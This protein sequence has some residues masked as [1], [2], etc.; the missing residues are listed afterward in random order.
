M[1]PESAGAHGTHAPHAGLPA[2]PLRLTRRQILAR[3]ETWVAARVPYSMTSLWRH[4]YRQDCSGFVSMAWGLD[5]NAW[6]GDLHDYAVRITKAAL[7]PGDILLFHNR[8][9]PR[10]GSHVI[11]FA[12]WSDAARTHYT[13]YEQT[14]PGTRVRTMPYA[15]WSHS[16]R[17][18]PYRYKYL[19]ARPAWAGG[20][21]FPGAGAFGPGADN[22]YVAR[23]GSLLIGRGAR[24]Y[25]RVGPGSTWGAADRRATRAFQRAQGWTGAAA[26]G[27]PGPTTWQYLVKHHGND[28]RARSRAAVP[29][30]HA[31][32]HYP[33]PAAFRPGRSSDAVL[34]LG[35]ELAAKG[36][37]G[38]DRTGPSRTW[39]E[40]V[41]R[42]VKAFQRAQGWSGRKADGYPGP[43]TWRRLFS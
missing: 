37:G 21:T 13:G 30:P 19:V 12:G 8:A 1:P 14:K 26:D 40:A 10:T 24:A 3:A 7:Q 20:N 35:R 25:Y 38:H 23:L 33:G 2:A 9:D 18:Q 6:T 42:N 43:E 36:F 41:R 28:V 15:Y 17:Y 29:A 32:P 39:G 31:V 34:A 5:V 22:F 27:L 4:G 11:V 16:A